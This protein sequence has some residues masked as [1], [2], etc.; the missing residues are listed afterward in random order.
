MK[1]VQETKTDRWNSIEGIFRIIERLRSE[2]GCPWDRKQTPETV[3]TYLVEESH[4]AAAAIRAGKAEEV[5]EELGDVLFMVFF[6][7]YLYEQRGD[8]SLEEVC[9]QVIE[10]M[11]RRH[12]H[13][14]GE[15]SISSAEEV[16]DNWEKIKAAEKRASGKAGEPV[17]GSLP[18]LIRTYRVLSRLSHR[19]D[20]EPGE[21]G[22]LND[23]QMQVRE[24]ARQSGDLA[25]RIEENPFEAED[26]LG[27]LLAM[28]VNIARLKGY[29][30]EDL[31]HNFLRKLD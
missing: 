5:A 31:L 20:G 18:A 4:E 17:P 1:K 16:K 26:A 21:F 12:P 9:G 23:L 14:F 13:V 25:G 2:T 28:I 7:V 3:Q 22:D 27:R 6:L 11:V 15:I 10:K 29:R 30:A 8:F 19:E 24:F